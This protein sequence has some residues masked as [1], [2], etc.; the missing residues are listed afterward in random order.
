MV[1]IGA[2]STGKRKMIKRIYCLGSTALGV[3][4][5]S[6][7]GSTTPVA[8]DMSNL[9]TGDT[10][11]VA[12]G[13]YIWTYTDHNTTPDPTKI[14]QTKPETFDYHATITPQTSQS[15]ALVPELDTDTTHGNV[16]HVK[17]QVPGQ[18]PWSLVSVQDPISVDTYWPSIPAYSDAMVPA[19]PAA[20][21]GFG[22]KP[23]NDVFDSSQGGK[24][25]GIAF[26]LKINVVQKAL[27][28]SFPMK[29]T[30]LPDPNNN[31]AFPKS[32][33][34][35][36][37]DNNPDTGGSSCFTSYR[38]GIFAESLHTGNAYNTLAAPNSWKRFCVLYSEVEVP[39]WANTKTLQLMTEIP[40]DPTKTIKVQWDMYQ[41]ADGDDPAAFDVSLDNIK[42]ITKDEAKDAANNCDPERIDAA[43]GTGDAG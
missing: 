16:I 14:V 27:Y 7:C 19:Y 28:V 17:G 38:K 5:L 39:T 33:T 21:V 11:Q 3:A 34:Y 2:A 22:F 18:I 42:L 25:V 23:G 35:Y 12:T 29:T 8:V 4:L 40:F 31:D 37:K 24:Y 1:P 6:A 30:D 32:C 26:D 9:S 36:T 15:V 10:N 41:P 13:G 20:G 43:P